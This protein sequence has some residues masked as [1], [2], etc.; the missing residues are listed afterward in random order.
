M[1]HL[2][3]AYLKLL[4]GFL[5]Q[6][7]K[8][9][10][11]HSFRKLQFHPWKFHFCAAESASSSWIF[12]PS[13]VKLCNFC[14]A[15]DKKKCKH[16]FLSFYLEY[17]PNILTWSLKWRWKFSQRELKTRK[18]CTKKLCISRKKGDTFITDLQGVR[19]T[20][21]HF[22]IAHSFKRPC[23]PMRNVHK[24]ACKSW[25]NKNAQTH[26]QIRI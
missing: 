13:L 15:S 2:T 18:T 3:K 20:F 10:Q 21:K 17:R 23:N 5:S 24:N 8:K 7:G 25:A 11:G 19:E 6:G 14:L 9:E 12:L 26:C 16:T 1:S 4:Q 22:E